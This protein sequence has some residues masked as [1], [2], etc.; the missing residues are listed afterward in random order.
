MTEWGSNVEAISP[1]AKENN[2]DKNNKDEVISTRSNLNRV[3][4]ELEDGKRQREE[5]C[6]RTHSTAFPQKEEK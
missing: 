6:S 3:I 2:G 1:K 5:N 4:I